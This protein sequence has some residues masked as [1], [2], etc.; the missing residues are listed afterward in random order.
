MAKRLKKVPAQFEELE[1]AF[2]DP[3]HPGWSIGSAEGGWAT[4][5]KEE[6]GKKPK[7][8]PAQKPAAS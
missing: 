3:N 1:K 4:P 6:W 5:S 7:P 8:P 2:R